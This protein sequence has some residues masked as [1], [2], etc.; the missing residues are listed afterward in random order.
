MSVRC[1]PRCSW[2][3][4]LSPGSAAPPQAAS[5][6]SGT[7]PELLLSIG[8]GL[9]WKIFVIL[10]HFIDLL[11]PVGDKNPAVQV[12]VGVPLSSLTS[13]LFNPHGILV[14]SILK[15]QD[16]GTWFLCRCWVGADLGTCQD[17]WHCAGLQETVRSPWWTWSLA[18]SSRRTESTGQ[19]DGSWS[20][21]VISLGER[22]SYHLD[23]KYFGFVCIV[24]NYI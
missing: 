16:L 21:Y 17:Q 18:G 3:S 12:N 7:A 15:C 14:N 2:C 11:A 23:R 5:G 9:V 1:P 22:T 8:P 20:C 10:H 13:I 24:V 4:S 6:S 19:T